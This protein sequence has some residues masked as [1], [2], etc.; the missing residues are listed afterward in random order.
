MSN[1]NKIWLKVASIISWI[2]AGCMIFFGLAVVFDFLDM[3]VLLEEYVS[4]QV[5]DP[6]NAHQYSFVRFFVMAEAL[7]SCVINIY[8]GCVC[9]S[10]SNKKHII[11]GASRVLVITGL[12]QLFCTANL[13]SAIVCFCVSRNINNDI[14]EKKKENNLEY[15]SYEIEKLRVL[16]DSKAITEEEFQSQLNII[17]AQYSKEND[18]KN[19]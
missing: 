5:H 9:W 4:M 16:R 12:F 3:R 18:N 19:K 10:L 8:S 6:S 13:F 14:I 1:V 7:F 11:A 17:L 2:F 15:I